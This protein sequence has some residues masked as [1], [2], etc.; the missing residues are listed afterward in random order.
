MFVTPVATT[1]NFAIVSIPE[2][3]ETIEPFFRKIGL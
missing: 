1:T 3:L 2:V